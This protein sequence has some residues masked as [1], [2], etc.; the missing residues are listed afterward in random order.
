[1]NVKMRDVRFAFQPS[2]SPSDCACA[3]GG[4]VAID[5]F[6]LTQSRAAK[7]S[8]RP[9]HRYKR[10]PHPPTHPP[11]RPNIAFQCSGLTPHGHR[12]AHSSPPSQTAEPELERQP[13]LLSLTFGLFAHFTTRSANAG[14]GRSESVGA[15]ELKSVFRL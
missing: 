15:R 2:V 7:V 4:G 13:L 12:N 9:T 10:D 6:L 8:C 14:G 5:R 3:G 11:A 1:M